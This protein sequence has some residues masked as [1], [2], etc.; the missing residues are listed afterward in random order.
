MSTPKIVRISLAKLRPDPEQPRKS[1]DGEKYAATVES[2]RTE[3]V[4]NAIDVRTDP[5]PESGY[6]YMIVNG[7]GRYLASLD[8]GKKFIPAII[9]N[10]RSNKQRFLHQLMDNEVRDNMNLKDVVM[11]Y[12]RLADEGMPLEK[13]AKSLGKKPA[14]I[15]ADLALLNLQEKYLDLLSQGKMPISVGRLLAEVKATKQDRIYARLARAR[16]T[17][18]QMA[19]IRTYLQECRQQSL[20]LEV[21]ERS[22]KKADPREVQQFAAQFLFMARK[23]RDSELS[24][25][26][27]PVVKCS[28][29]RLAELE[30]AAKL[31]ITM[32]RSMET[33]IAEHR[34]KQA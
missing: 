1:R 22:L 18:E 31:L 11:A 28:R 5:D 21:E 34:A 25:N 17:K 10:Y 24:G 8:A 20:C 27:E 12:K 32:G 15:E 3:G 16:S 30:Q 2:I 9:R 19:I 13:I 29:K 23:F 6:A 14:A 26:P 33:A 4:K 7:E